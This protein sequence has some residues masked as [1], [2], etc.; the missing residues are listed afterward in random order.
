MHILYPRIL[1]YHCRVAWRMNVDLE[2]GETALGEGT[3]GS[4]RPSDED[5]RN[6]VET[7][8]T[9]TFGALDMC[10]KPIL[11]HLC[12]DRNLRRAS[13]KRTLIKTLLNW[14][15]NQATGEVPS[16]PF[17]PP[18]PSKKIPRTDTESARLLLEGTATVS[19]VSLLHFTKPILAS[20]CDAKCEHCSGNKSDLVARLLDWWGEQQPPGAEQ[21]QYNNNVHLG[22]KRVQWI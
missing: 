8:A 9:G 6:G 11:Y 22:A 21:N 1:R 7:L 2:D 13:T 15:I 5:M 20:L 16:K 10:T 12:Q 19:D 14:K 3:K 17:I 18:R 4:A